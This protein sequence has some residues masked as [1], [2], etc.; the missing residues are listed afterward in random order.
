MQSWGKFP[1]NKALS[2]GHA[3]RSWLCFI[4]GL[5]QDYIKT[6]WWQLK[7]FLFSPL[8]FG[9]DSHFDEHIIQRGWF[10]HQLVKIFSLQLRRFVAVDVVELSSPPDIIL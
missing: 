4:Y 5:I 6:R 1:K 8:L 7:C 10:S 9:E 3:E 2:I